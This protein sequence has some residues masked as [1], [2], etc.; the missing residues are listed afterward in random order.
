[1]RHHTVQSKLDP[2]LRKENLQSLAYTE[3]KYRH[4]MVLTCLTSR[5]VGL[6]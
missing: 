6:E 1:M 2:L 4:Y 3:I 5:K